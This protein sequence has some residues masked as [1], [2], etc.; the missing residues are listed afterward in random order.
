MFVNTSEEVIKM[1]ST[2]IS[3]VP[4]YVFSPNNIRNLLLEISRQIA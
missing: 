1:A 2:E 4:E 3:E